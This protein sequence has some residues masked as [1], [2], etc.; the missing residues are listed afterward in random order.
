MSQFC[1]LVS[2][3]PHNCGEFISNVANKAGASGGTIVMGRGTAATTVLQMLGLGETSKDIVYIVVDTAKKQDI[4]SAIVTSCEAK[5]K[6]FGILFSIDTF[7]FVKSGTE[8]GGVEDMSL[9]QKSHQM[10][11]IIVNKGYAE[12]VMAA[13]RKAGAGGGTIINA[14]GTAREDD[15]TFFGV[16]IVPEK[17]MVLI[18]TEREKVSA[19][20]ESVKNLACL[21]EPGSGIAYCTP[22]DDFSML[23]KKTV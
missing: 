20:L 3:V 11:T 17:E 22:T 1:L 19:I 5:K 23:G 14:R 16:S 8:V 7:T 18:L 13:A 2:I 6:H 10:I 21:S 4:V 15:A 9:E 12:D